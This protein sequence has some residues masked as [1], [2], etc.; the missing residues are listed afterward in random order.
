MSLT[1]DDRKCNY[2]LTIDSTDFSIDI[3]RSST[4]EQ[5]AVL[6]DAYSKALPLDTMRG[7]GCEYQ[8]VDARK[9]DLE[10]YNQ[11]QAQVLC[12]QE[13]VQREILWFHTL[14]AR[15]ELSTSAGGGGDNDSTVPPKDHALVCGLRGGVTNQEIQIENCVQLARILHRELVVPRPRVNDQDIWATDA[16]DVPFSQLWD[17]RAFA[18]YAA[19][20]G[21]G[22]IYDDVEV[23][24][25]GQSKSSRLQPS[26]QAQ[27]WRMEVDPPEPWTFERLGPAAASTTA[28]GGTQYSTDMREGGP[29]VVTA[30]MKAVPPGLRWPAAVEGF[31]SAFIDEYEPVVLAIA[32]FMTIT[33]SLGL[34]C[35]VP[36]EGLRARAAALRRTLPEAGFD[37]VHARIEQDW[38]CG[39]MSTSELANCSASISAAAGQI[40]LALGKADPPV[41]AG[42]ALFVAT[43][44][45][46]EHLAPFTESGYDVH[47]QNRANR[48]SVMSY[49]A[50]LIDRLVCEQADRFFG[51][52]DSTFSHK[53]NEIRLRNN[54]SH[55]IWYDQILNDDG[56][57]VYGNI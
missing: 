10:H 39:Q 21:V 43:G 15:R 12:L 25:S 26:F 38:T 5:V 53:T 14:C 22:L 20:E 29:T 18:A 30:S 8:P 37:C 48:V 57:Y 36:N 13:L 32:P 11:S 9:V 34:R 33:A 28:Q 1:S 56:S 52:H 3:P 35:C 4:A 46:A 40:A 6:A 44:A 42:R 41:P 54:R 50:A 23:D 19:Q 7:A 55:A 31:L 47:S 27:L 16:L 49:S 2:L 17:E 51:L 24:E 45:P